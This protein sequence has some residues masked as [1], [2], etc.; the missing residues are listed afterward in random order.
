MFQSLLLFLL[1]SHIMIVMRSD[2]EYR[3][4]LDLWE[5]GFAKK[6]IAIMTGIPR[7]TVSDCIVR[8]DSIEGL[9]K[10]RRERPDAPVAL[11]I[12]KGDVN[13]EHLGIREA[14]TYL[15]GMYLGDGYI[16]KEP[17]TYKLRIF[18]AT[19]YPNIISM[20]LDTIQ[21][22]LPHNKAS[23]FQGRGNYV[24]VISLN[25]FWPEFLPQHGKG[26]KHTRPIILEDWQVRLVNEF[27]LLFFKGLYHSDGSRSRNF[28][29][30]KD[31]PRYE[32]CNHSEDIKRIFCATCD[33][34]GLHWTVASNGKII[35]IARRADVTFLDQYIG[36]KS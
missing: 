4:I 22:L 20:C 35:Q 11:R 13:Q 10:F 34:I 15:L 17:R 6:R 2:E 26:M 9:E 28:V 5:Q 29:K 7:G 33:L 21:T 14:Y 24:E 3:E 25:N 30:G 8:F 19:A 32:F 18:L 12:L 1:T 36:P 23:L 27:P 31:Y 16:N